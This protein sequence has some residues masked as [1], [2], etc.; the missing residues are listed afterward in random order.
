MDEIQRTVDISA[1]PEVV[2]ALVSD[3][4]R[5]GEFSPENTGGEWVRGATGPNVGARFKGTNARGGHNWST[6]ATVATYLVPTEFAF[7]VS[8]GPFKVARWSYAIAATHD[9]CRVT[10]TS[11]DRR[12]RLLKMFERGGDDRA[13]FTAESIEHTLANIKATCERSG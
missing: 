5:M 1:S 7:E 11:V 6:I 13:A 2:F 9:G 12:G 3:L 10:E 4:E 8:A